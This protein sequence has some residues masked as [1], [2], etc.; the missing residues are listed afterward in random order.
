[1]RGTNTGNIADT[2]LITGTG[3]AANTLI[4]VTYQSTYNGV[5]ITGNVAIVDVNHPY[6]DIR[7]DIKI[8]ARYQAKDNYVEI[9]R[10][11]FI[12][13]GSVVL[14]NVKIGEGVVVGANSV[15]TTDIPSFSVA[16]VS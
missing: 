4:N 8:G 10:G 13:F 6:D 5:S 1:M 15:V 3:I 16:T 2:S 9:G 11:S 14:P 12:G 7:S